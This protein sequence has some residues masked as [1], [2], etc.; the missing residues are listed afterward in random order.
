MVLCVEDANR[1]R[2]NEFILGYEKCALF[3]LISKW[4]AVSFKLSSN[5]I[6]WQRNIVPVPESVRAAACVIKSLPGIK[7]QGSSLTT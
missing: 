5:I 2:R 7:S 3:W 6:M 4:S 1:K